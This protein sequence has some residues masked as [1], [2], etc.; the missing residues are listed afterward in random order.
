VIHAK[1]EEAL[2]TQICI[3]I[4]TGKML[5]SNGSLAAKTAALITYSTSAH[6]SGKCI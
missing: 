5:G 4:I 2:H 3:C 1:Q 6:A